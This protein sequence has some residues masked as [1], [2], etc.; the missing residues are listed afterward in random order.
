M[1]SLPEN[2]NYIQTQQDLF[3]L[4]KVIPDDILHIIV[5]GYVPLVEFEWDPNPNY[6]H[7]FYRSPCDTS[8]TWKGQYTTGFWENGHVNIE[9]LCGIFVDCARRMKY[10]QNSH[11]NI[12]S[13]IKTLELNTRTI[14]HDR[15][16]ESPPLSERKL[17]LLKINCDV[18]YL[19]V[20]L[21]LVVNTIE[22]SQYYNRKFF[23]NKNNPT[24]RTNLLG[25]CARGVMHAC[26]EFF[27]A[28]TCF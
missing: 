11:G 26:Y 2:N 18:E 13:F 7:P 3:E 16:N 28:R 24:S 17:G 14:C 1:S 23:A 4:Y 6:Q 25:I 9:F 15:G 5:F 12:C 10:L 27:L 8:I 20:E 19:V 22:T 21:K